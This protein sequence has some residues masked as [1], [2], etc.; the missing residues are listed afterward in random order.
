MKLVCKSL[1]G[2][3]RTIFSQAHDQQRIVNPARE[4]I[5]KQIF[6]LSKLL[7]VW[8]DLLCGTQHPNQSTVMCWNH[9]ATCTIFY[10]I[11][12]L[13]LVDCVFG[14]NKEKTNLIGISCNSEFFEIDQKLA[15]ELPGHFFICD[16]TCWLYSE[17]LLCWSPRFVVTFHPKGKLKGVNTFHLHM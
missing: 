7:W 15:H 17:L 13:C 8:Q 5:W 16:S 12:T 2:Q 6:T 10:G 3:T 4:Q 14:S 9:K 11:F 1:D